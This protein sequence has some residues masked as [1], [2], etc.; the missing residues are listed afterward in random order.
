[1]HKFDLDRQFW[2]MGDESGQTRIG[3]IHHISR[4]KTGDGSVSTPVCR[5]YVWRPEYTEG[6]HPYWRIDCFVREHPLAGE[7]SELA[8]MLASQMIKHGLIEEPI[9]NSWH[10]STEL[11]GEAM[12]ELFEDD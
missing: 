1:M 2:A 11:D 9:W 10:K 6:V 3:E 5:Y 7:P 8:K 12:G 4:N